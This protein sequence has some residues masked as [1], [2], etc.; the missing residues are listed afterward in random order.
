MQVSNMTDAIKI[1][2]DFLSIESLDAS[3]QLLGDFRTQRLF[4]RWP[5]DVLQIETS[6][7]HAWNSL[8]RLYAM[9]ASREQTNRSPAISNSQSDPHEGMDDPPTTRDNSKSEAEMKREKRRLKRH[10]RRQQMAIAERPYKPGF[11]CRCLY[12]P[13]MCNKNG[14][15]FHL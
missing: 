11:D 6:V 12:C 10:A 4:C 3:Y 14:L 13:R 1:A 5:E 15:I 8:S 7:W 2:C 9:T